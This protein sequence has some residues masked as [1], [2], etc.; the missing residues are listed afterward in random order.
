MMY[1]DVYAMMAKAGVTKELDE[2]VH[3]DR[4]GNSAIEDDPKRYGWKTKHVLTHPERVLFINEVGANTN[5]KQ[6]IHIGGIK[7]VV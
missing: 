1:D 6:D 4:Q 2:W 5:Q 7:L 3:Q